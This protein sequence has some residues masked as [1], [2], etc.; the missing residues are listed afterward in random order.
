MV[1]A[2]DPIANGFSFTV[3][4]PSGA[5]LFSRHIPP[6]AAPDSS[7][8]GWKVNSAH[9]HWVFHDSDGTVA[10]GIIR[11]T[12]ATSPNTP[13]LFKVNVVGKNGQFHMLPTQ[14][15]VQLI[16]VLG[17]DAQGIAG[18]CGTFAFNQA[19]EP[20]PM[21]QFVGFADVRCQ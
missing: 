4:D 9:T 17:G 15:P 13:E 12:I 7:S 10:P 11:V 18:Q 3:F 6:G 5:L 14:I 19:F 16:I 21:C 1:P 2:I 20:P 8:P